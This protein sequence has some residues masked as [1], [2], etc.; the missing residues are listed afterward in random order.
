MN[1]NILVTFQMKIK[2]NNILYTTI[3]FISSC[4]LFYP[5]VKVEVPTGYKGWCHIVPVYDTAE[6]RFVKNDEKY[7]SDTNGIIY[8]PFYLID[9]PNDF[10]VKIYE[11]DRE[12]TSQAKYQGRSEKSYSG[13]SMKYISIQFYLL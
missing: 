2:S 5:V 7:V 3:F 13:D 8:V 4:S 9:S 6:F 10:M 12:I 1:L 11:N